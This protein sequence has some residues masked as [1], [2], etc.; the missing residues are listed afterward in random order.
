MAKKNVNVKVD[1]DNIDVNIERKDGDLKVNILI[2]NQTIL[3]ITV[4]YFYQTRYLSY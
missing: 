1:T 2:K 3:T 4:W